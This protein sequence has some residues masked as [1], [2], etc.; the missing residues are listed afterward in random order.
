LQ[1]HIGKCVDPQNFNKGWEKVLV[2]EGAHITQYGTSEVGALQPSE[3][4]M[5][6]ENVPFTGIDY[7]EIG[8]INFAEQAPL[9]ITQEIVDVLIPDSISCG[10]C[11]ITSDGC[12][13][14]LLL[15]LR[16]GGSPGTGANVS[17]TKNAGG[18]WVNREI[19]TLTGSNDPNAL[20][21]ISGNVV[22]ISEETTGLMYASL[23][24]LLV[25]G[26]TW[27]AVTTGFVAAKGPRAIY[28]ADPTHT[29]I[30]GTG[31]Y[32]YFTADPTASVSVQD[33]GVA[34]YRTSSTC[35]V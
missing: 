2:L 20:A 4:S 31:G 21:V 8:R 9:Y 19:T 33:A 28:T 18:T 13:V 29:W 14:I 3:R 35:T 30:V 11:G 10:E 1:I 27:A 26:E 12:Q 5:V 7:Y 6:D 34:T 17:Y 24:D 25:S 22:V 32:I 23:A 16:T 15:S